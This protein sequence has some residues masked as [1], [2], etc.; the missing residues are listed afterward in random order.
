M[1]QVNDWMRYKRYGEKVWGL[2]TEIDGEFVI[3]QG[4]N[5]LTGR[6]TQDDLERVSDL[7]L[8]AIL[9]EKENAVVT[10]RK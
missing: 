5:G 9:Q 3:F 4:V 10:T 6:A 8:L 1:L 7:E 2:V